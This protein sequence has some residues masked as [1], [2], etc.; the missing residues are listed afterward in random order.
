[1]TSAPVGVIWESKRVRVET[2]RLGVGTGCAR[3]ASVPERL[4]ERG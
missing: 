3:E 2:E 1:M 4:R